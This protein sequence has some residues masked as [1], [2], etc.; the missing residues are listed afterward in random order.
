MNNPIATLSL[1]RKAGKL[2]IGY[3]ATKNSLLQKQ[4]SLI[5][6]TSDISNG[7]LK[8]IKTYASGVSIVEIPF[9][10]DDIEAVL[11]RRFA[12]AAITDTNFSGIERIYLRQT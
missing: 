4:A 10:Q 2:S 1:A 11:H 8:K 12:V 9:T 6:V 5:V 7:T 3:T